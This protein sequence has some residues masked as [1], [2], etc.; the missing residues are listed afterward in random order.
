MSLI[1]S[2]NIVTN[3]LLTAAIV[4]W[5]HRDTKSKNLQIKFIQTMQVVWKLC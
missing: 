4:M 2:G 5:C 3:T 1:Q